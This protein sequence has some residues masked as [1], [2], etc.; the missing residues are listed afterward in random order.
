M[1]PLQPDDSWDP[2]LKQKISEQHYVETDLRAIR[3]DAIRKI[4][5]DHKLVQRGPHIVCLTCPGHEANYIGNFQRL[6][7]DSEGRYTLVPIDELL[8]GRLPS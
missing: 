2:L 5:K 4:P 6:S 1:P 8:P 3:A 7:K